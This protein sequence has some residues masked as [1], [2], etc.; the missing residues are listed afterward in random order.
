MSKFCF[1]CGVSTDDESIFCPRCGVR[2][3][4]PFAPTI[5]Q[6]APAPASETTPAEPISPAPTPAPVKTRKKKMVVVLASVFALILLA[7]GSAIYFLFFSPSYTDPI[8]LYFDAMYEGKVENVEKLAPDEYWNWRVEA[9]DMNRDECIEEAQEWARLT[10]KSIK[11][12][13]GEDFLCTYEVA[14]KEELSDEALQE[15]AEILER[16]YEI[17]AKSVK[18]GYTVTID[19]NFN[20]DEQKGQEIT[21]VQIG[22][23]WYLVERYNSSFGNY[24]YF[25]V[26]G[27]PATFG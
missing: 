22:Y 20:G 7:A 13:F 16:D 11:K 8:D 26:G 3:D 21:V 12:Q 27:T 23:R 19:L 6:A 5:P 17:S 9:S 18:Q 2:I 4:A 25:P 14:D 1:K 24:V 15:L 10:N